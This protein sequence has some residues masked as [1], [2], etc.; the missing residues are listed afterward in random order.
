MIFK[1]IKIFLQNVWKNNLIINMIL[2]TQFSFNIIFIQKLS[3]TT[4]YSIPSFK[5]RKGKDLVGVLSHPNWLMFANNTSNINDYL[6]VITYVN[7]RLS[8]FCFSLWKNIY[9]HRD[10]LPVF[11]FNNNKVFFLIN[12]YSDLLQLALKY[13]KDTEVDVYNVLVI[14]ILEIVNGILTFYTILALVI[15]YLTLWIFYLWVYQ[16]L[17]TVFLLDTWTIV[18]I[19]DML[20]DVI[21]LVCSSLF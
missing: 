18:K 5:S 1:D 8:V 3:W 13:L 19:F 16:F 21:P 2:E 4:I 6:R 14:L 12:I 9:N 20:L 10:I 15:Y 7:I 17:L 11:F